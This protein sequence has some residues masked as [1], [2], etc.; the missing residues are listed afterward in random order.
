MKSA[1]AIASLALALMIAGPG[2]AAPPPPVP[3]PPELEKPI[4]GYDL[5]TPYQLWWYWIERSKGPI[6]E[7]VIDTPATP[8]PGERAFGQR[9]LYFKGFGEMGLFAG[10]D[11]QLFC[12]PAQPYG[13]DKDSCHIVLRKVSIPVEVGGHSKPTSLSRWMRENFDGPALARH[14]KAEGVSPQT[15]WWFADRARIFAASASPAAALKAELRVDRVDSRDCP[16]MAKA[17]SALDAAS[18]DLRLDLF[19]VGKDAVPRAP[20]PHSSQWVYTLGLMR[21]DGAV[22]LETTSRA[23]EAHVVPILKAADACLAP[24]PKP[25]Q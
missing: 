16:A 21:E 1:A 15:D 17:F 8:P 2:A 4:D 25:Q 24:A 11:A 23:V 19:G 5:R 6:I 3:T 14:L 13:F 18:L 10:G 20:M 7:A 12:R 9:Q 22:T